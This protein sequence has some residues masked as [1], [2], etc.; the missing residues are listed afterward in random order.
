MEWLRPW[1]SVH[2]FPAVR[3][4]RDG[5]IFNE[6]DSFCAAVLLWNL[7]CCVVVHRIVVTRETWQSAPH[8]LVAILSR[9]LSWVLD[10]SPSLDSRWHWCCASTGQ[11]KRRAHRCIPIDSHHHIYP[12]L[13][14]NTFLPS[15][16]SQSFASSH[17]RILASSPSSSQFPFVPYL[18][19]PSKTQSPRLQT[20][21]STHR[22]SNSP[23]QPHTP[24][25]LYTTH[26]SAHPRS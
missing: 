5:K 8:D 24:P 19:A 13:S 26:P 14:R 6:D 20:S 25:P 12:C 3:Q 2:N 18:T 11:K 17:P 7:L 9:L 10:H 21:R 16:L 23:P 22:H 15:A 1:P 4:R